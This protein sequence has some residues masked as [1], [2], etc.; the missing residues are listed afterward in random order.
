[1]DSIG[2]LPIAFVKLLPIAISGQPGHAAGL[3]AR[4]RSI[5]AEP[6]I[7]SVHDERD[8]SVAQALG[9]VLGQGGFLSEPRPLK[10]DVAGD[11]R[12]GT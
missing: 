9:I 2:D 10:A 5:G 8:I 7:D 1:M 11:T 12:T 3:V 4:I 6:V